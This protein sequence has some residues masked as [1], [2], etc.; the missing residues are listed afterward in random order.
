MDHHTTWFGHD[1]GYNGH[2]LS[3]VQQGVRRVLPVTCTTILMGTSV[4]PVRSP[5]VSFHWGGKKTQRFCRAYAWQKTLFS[6]KRENTVLLFRFTRL[7]FSRAVAKF[8]FLNF[9]ENQSYDWTD[10]ATRGLRHNWSTKPIWN[11]VVSFLFFSVN[12]KINYPW[13]CFIT[14]STDR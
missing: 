5:W 2:C 4:G 12:T 3:L 13:I 7:Q 10:K 1:N 9:A 6:W 14:K 8:T 11:I